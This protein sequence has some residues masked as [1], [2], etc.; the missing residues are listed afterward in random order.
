MLYEIKCKSCNGRW[1][2]EEDDA[3]YCDPCVISGQ[4]KKEEEMK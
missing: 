4:H 1:I 3:V 2:S